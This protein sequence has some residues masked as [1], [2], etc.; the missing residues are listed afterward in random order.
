MKSIELGARLASASAF[1]RQG[2]VFA[3]IGTDHGYLPLFLIEQGRIDRS[4]CSDINCGPLNTAMDNAR[5]CG[6]DDRVQTVLTDGLEGLSG[7]GLTD[8]AICGM[9]GELI[10]AII[11][12][13]PWVRDPSVRLIL[14]PMS[15]Q[16]KLRRYLAESGFEILEE[17]YSTETSKNYLCLLACYSGKPRQMSLAESVVGVTPEDPSMLNSYCRY[18]RD[19][20]LGAVKARDGRPT[21]ERAVFA[22]LAEAIEERIAAVQKRINETII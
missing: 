5:L 17:S 21:D 22:E 2:A 4:V 18:L 7:L 10:S 12:R 9:G 13:A 20:L 19:K 14:Q 3:D 15:R 16:D 1:V 11:D 8:I 6:L